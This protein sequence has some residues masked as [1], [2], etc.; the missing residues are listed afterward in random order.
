M[1]SF[2]RLENGRII[3]RDSF[4]LF[5]YYVHIIVGGIVVALSIYL[6]LWPIWDYSVVEEMF[7]YPILF[8][9]LSPVITV[10]FIW[11]Y[12]DDAN[13]IRFEYY[14]AYYED[15]LVFSLIRKN[16]I[17][18]DVFNI[19]LHFHSIMIFYKLGQ[20]NKIRFIRL[21]EAGEKFTSIPYQHL[22]NEL[23]PS[24]KH[25]PFEGWCLEKEIKNNSNEIIEFLNHR[26]QDC[27]RLKKKPSEHCD[28]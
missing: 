8:L 27:K 14:V 13:N 28:T 12:I 11:W 2:E 10:F 16:L 24:D 7:A 23:N 19:Q 26:V 3:F 18:D 4:G 22:F 21:N 25:R 20:N 5:K 9:I 17:K 1:E 6:S 15:F